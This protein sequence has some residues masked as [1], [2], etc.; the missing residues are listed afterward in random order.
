MKRL[1]CVLTLVVVTPAAWALNAD[2][3]RGGWQ[4][5]V[6]GTMRIYEFTIRGSSVRGRGLRPVR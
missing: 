6:D 5:K 1:L 4:I 2:D 3:V